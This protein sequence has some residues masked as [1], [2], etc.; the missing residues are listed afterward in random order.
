[1][2][3]RTSFPT[4]TGPFVVGTGIVITRPADAQSGDLIF[5]T[6]A[7]DRGAA[8]YTITPPAGWTLLH[9]LSPASTFG[10]FWVYWRVATGSDPASWA[11]GVPANDS[12]GA[13]IASAWYTPSGATPV[14]YGQSLLLTPTGT[15][16]ASPALS[17]N[18]IGDTVVSMT[19]MNNFPP[20]GQLYAV[21][22]PS[23]LQIARQ[24]EGHSEV[25]VAVFAETPRTSLGAIPHVVTLSQPPSGGFPDRAQAFGIF[26]LGGP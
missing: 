2:R 6:I 18:R 13:A 19:G 10:S 8:A 9:M 3:P 15:T 1:M 25:T 12:T 22:S 20:A 24:Y 26:A 4:H 7:N 17:I 16:K 23:G 21:D 11:F 5:A 14:I